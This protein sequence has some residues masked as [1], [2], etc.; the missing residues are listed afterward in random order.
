MPGSSSKEEIKR[1]STSRR[2]FMWAFIILDVLLFAYL[3]VE[4]VL[5]LI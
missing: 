3:I 1:K 5:A 4:I 2:R